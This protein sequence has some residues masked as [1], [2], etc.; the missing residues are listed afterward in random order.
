MQDR[1]IWGFRALRGV[2]LD[3][4]LTQNMSLASCA[5][6]EPWRSDAAFA[7]DSQWCPSARWTSRRRRRVLFGSPRSSSGAPCGARIRLI[8]RQL[9]C[10]KPWTQLA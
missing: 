8:R 7:P 9:A 4:Q 6:H 2:Q 10:L 1:R 5:G 3:F